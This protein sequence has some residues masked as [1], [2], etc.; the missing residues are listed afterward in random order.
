M[1]IATYVLMLAAGWGGFGIADSQLSAE[2]EQ[3][4]QE[5]GS[6]TDALRMQIEKHIENREW[7]EARAAVRMLKPLLSAKERKEA[8]K[9]LFK[10]AGREAYFTI[11][12]DWN[13]S[14]HPRK[15]AKQISK[16]LKKY[17]KVEELRQLAV[18]LKKTFGPPRAV[19]TATSGRPSRS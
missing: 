8:S 13:N 1:P 12:N 11:R 6:E 18:E 16:F 2:Q 17:G 9:L 4:V 5:K 19:T 3:T 15:A 14:P 7:K 10:I